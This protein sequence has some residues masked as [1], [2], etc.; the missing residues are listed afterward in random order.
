LRLRL[1]ITLRLVP[2][3]TIRIPVRLAQQPG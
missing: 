1:R 3:S 2:T